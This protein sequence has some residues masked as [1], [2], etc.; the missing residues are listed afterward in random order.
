MLRVFD[1]RVAAVPI[2]AFAMVAG[3]RQPASSLP[4]WPSKPRMPVFTAPS[5]A[6]ESTLA[7]VGNLYRPAVE[8]VRYERRISGEA[9]GADRCSIGAAAGT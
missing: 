9:S 6:S 5:S 3:K 8:T 4:H 1:E 7:L 2:A